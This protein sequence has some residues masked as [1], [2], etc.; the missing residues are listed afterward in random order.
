MPS[1]SF[2]PGGVDPRKL[3]V[4]TTVE[5]STSLTCPNRRVDYD[6]WR[7]DAAPRIAI[8]SLGG[9]GGSHASA[10]QRASDFEIKT[11]FPCRARQNA[12]RWARRRGSAD[13]RAV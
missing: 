4:A 10:E 12:F 2:L 1:Q 7:V 13:H 11:Q 9:A 3:L 6:R 5:T 8:I